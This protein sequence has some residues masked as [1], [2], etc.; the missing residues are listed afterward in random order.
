LNNNRRPRPHSAANQ[1]HVDAA[2][3]RQQLVIV[4]VVSAKLPDSVAAAI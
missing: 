2:S 3:Q 4:V 1:L